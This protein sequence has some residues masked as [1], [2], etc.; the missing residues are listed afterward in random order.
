[1]LAIIFAGIY[2]FFRERFFLAAVLLGV[3][4]NFHALYSLFPMFYMGIYL[5]WQIKKHGIKTLLMACGAFI[6]AA[7]PF[8]V[9]A[10]QHRLMG[11]GEG[12]PRLYQNWLELYYI[13]CP[14]N[15]PFETMPI[16]KLF[17][18]WDVFFRQAQL[19]LFLAG[20]FILNI[21]FNKRFRSDQ[22]AIAFS[23]G[24]FLLLVA[25]FVFAYA[26]PSRFVIDLNLIRNTQYLLF[27]LM[28][29]TCVLCVDVLDRRKPVLA[30]GFILAFVLIKYGQAMGAIATV[31]MACLLMADNVISGQKEFVWKMLFYAV[32][33]GI[34]GPLLYYV[35]QSFAE[36]NFEQYAV[37]SLRVLLVSLT[38]LFCVLLFRKPDQRT[39]LWMRSLLAV[40]LL[41]YFCQYTFFHFKKYHEENYSEGGFWSLQR[42]WED[43]QRFVKSNTAKDAMILVPYNMEMGGLRIFSDRKIIASYRDCGII[44]FD[45]PAAVEWQQRM[46]DIKPFKVIMKE[47]PQKAIENAVVKYKAD[48]IVFMGRAVPKSSPLLEKVYTNDYFALFKVIPNTL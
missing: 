12:N 47:S 45:Y 35:V 39:L 48:Y 30:L 37:F 4:A 41:I 38:G 43:M 23:I 2:F 28:G 11:V 32:L 18:S 19:Y 46:E 1:A 13:A 31:M 15:F 9:W 42:S 21:V 7:L 16:D 20:L 6:L 26:Y 25:C 5:L 29:Y 8:V 44:G 40:P 33:A 34:L 24:A 36:T 14:Q 3:A 17:F 22:K 27:L 10:V